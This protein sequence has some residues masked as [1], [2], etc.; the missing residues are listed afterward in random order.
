MPDSGA[1]L[2][3]KPRWRLPRL[4]L[5]QG[6][7]HGRHEEGCHASCSRCSSRTGPCAARETRGAPGPGQARESRSAERPCQARGRRG[8][9]RCPAR[10]SRG[11]PSRHRQRPREDVDA[12]RRLQI[13]SGCGPWPEG[14][15]VGPLR[16]LVT[17]HPLARWV[18][19]QS[20]EEA[21][22]RSVLHRHVYSRR[23]PRDRARVRGQRD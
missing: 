7:H 23:R 4:A 22:Q 8:A 12:R 2:G 18:P 20:S 10:G 13:R 19:P 16:L 9:P 1:W 5:G 3:L 17:C 11:A 14:V 6:L 21:R 15:C